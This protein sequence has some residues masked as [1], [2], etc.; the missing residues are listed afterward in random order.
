VMLSNRQAVYTASLIGG[1]GRLL[2]L[3]D[4]TLFAQPFDPA[5]LK[6][7]GDAVP[8]ADQVGSFSPATTG[9][10]SVSE[11]GVLAYRVGAGGD[12]RQL[13]WFDPQG[14]VLGT[15]GEKA[16]NENPAVSPDGTRVAVTQFDRQNG[17]SN[18]WVMDVS[19]GTSTKVTFNAGRNDFPE[20][21]PDAKSIAFSS[22]RGGHMDLYVKNADGSGEERL[23]LKSE[24]DKRP[25]SWSRDGRFLVYTSVNPKTREDLWVLPLNIDP[26]PVLLLSTDFQERFGSLS[27]DGHWIAYTSNEAGNDEIYVRPFS[28]DKIGESAA[29]G[30]WLVSRGGGVVPQWR[31]DGKELF[32]FTVALQQMAV[33]VSTE[34]TFQPG[35]PRRLFTIPLLS[36]GDVRA[37]GKRFVFPA[38]E[39]S[40]APSPF[41]VVTNWQAALKK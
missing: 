18:I 26:K 2:F 5:R 22:N 14:K 10:Y 37:D 19:R 28:P 31:G 34:K 4:T 24:E 20:W 30:K 17:N 21:S 27:P 6:L 15:V 12:L 33:D 25:D 13:T 29:G 39:G 3:R 38:P 41:T 16:A 35:V 32:Y 40:N 11:T 8:V 9:L 23:L 36:P 7:S 1:P